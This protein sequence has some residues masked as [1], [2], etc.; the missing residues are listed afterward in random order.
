[1]FTSVSLQKKPEKFDCNSNNT[2]LGNK[3]HV[4]FKSSI[5]F[6]SFITYLNFFA[7]SFLYVSRISSN[8]LFFRAILTVCQGGSTVF[9]SFSRVRDL[10]TTLLVAM[11]EGFSV[12]YEEVVMVWAVKMPWCRRKANFK[13]RWLTLETNFNSR[14]VKWCFVSASFLHILYSFSP[15]LVYFFSPGS[16]SFLICFP[17]SMCF[18]PTQQFA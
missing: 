18:E 12:L 2:W 4:Q 9:C 11:A 3:L 15:S 6:N 1:M 14:W 5:Y 8:C 13:P 7:C 17:S 10:P 16:F